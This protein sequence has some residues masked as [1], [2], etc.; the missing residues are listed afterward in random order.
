MLIDVGSL[1]DGATI[2]LTGGT[3][4][5][6]QA[7]TAEVLERYHLRKL[8]I[9]SRSESRQAAMKERFPETLG[10]VMRY[11]IGDV[12]SKDRLLSAFEGADIVIHAAAMK[13][14]ETCERE[15]KECTTVNVMGTLN[16]TEAARECGVERF[17]YI[18]SDKA[19]A[20]C[21]LYGASK[22]L[23]ERLV[24]QSNVYR[25]SRTIRY[26]AVRYG[27]VLGSTG[28]VLQTFQQANGKVPITHP[29]MSRFWLTPS[30]AARFCLTSLVL[31]RGGEVFC[32]RL[33]AMK[34]TD[35]ARAFAPDT[36]QEIVGL[37][38]AEKRAEVLIS[39]D[40]AP[41]T[42][43]LPDRFAILPTSPTWPMSLWPDACKV[44]EGFSYTSANAP[45][46]LT[47][48]QLKMMIESG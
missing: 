31:M 40:E 38:G 42:V 14:I 43:E 26:S 9:L 28:S 25:G 36:E 27:N 7:I 39:A 21:T 1:L 12:R 33:P 47:P 44:P 6:C 16:A 5:L 10:G 20:A 22:Y 19:T 13:R 46:R 3:G 11:F 37:R 41:W 30:R 23:A 45:D 29:E 34:V 17:L 35:M 18:S 32:P 4:T 15:P 48:E 2:V 24:V 8:V